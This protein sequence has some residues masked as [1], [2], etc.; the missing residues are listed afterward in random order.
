MKKKLLILVFILTCFISHIT[1]QINSGIVQDSEG[2]EMLPDQIGKIK[3]ETYYD[4][5]YSKTIPESTLSLYEDKLDKLISAF[6]NQYLFNPPKGFDVNFNKRIEE[7]DKE[8]IP[9]GFAIADEKKIAASLEIAL[10]PYFNINGK[11]VTDFHIASILYIYINNPYNIAGTPLIADIYTCP[12]VVDE[13]YDHSFYITNRREL[14]IINYTGKPLFIPVSQEDF[15]NTVIAY[16]EYKID[17]VNKGQGALQENEDEFYSDEAIKQRD[18]E[19]N[20]AYNEL[21]KYDKN[22]A[23]ELKKN[24]KE[25]VYQLND[26]P[27]NTSDLTIFEKEQIRLLKG[28]LQNMSLD[29]KKRQAY[30]YSGAMEKFNNVSGLLPKEYNNLGDP[31]VRI[32]PDLVLDNP[33]TVQLVSIHWYLLNKQDFSDSPRQQS[34]SNDA[35]LLTDNII[36]DLYKDKNFWKN[37]FSILQQK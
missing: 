21:L 25:L 18:E 19:F 30:Y 2:N 12:K 13:F 20:K 1:A 8:Y 32:N 3:V 4:D 35:G 34:Y 27:E 28:E 7:W 24:Y 5:T 15:I 26:K 31:L 6:K 36:L 11:A 29:E 33:K 37:I 23:E 14:T 22:A 17:E 10:A 16:W 9:A